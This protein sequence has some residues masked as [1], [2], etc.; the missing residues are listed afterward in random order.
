MRALLGSAISAVIFVQPSI[1]AVIEM[2]VLF[3]LILKMQLR[4]FSN[5]TLVLVSL[6]ICALLVALFNASYIILDVMKYG[7]SSMIK[8]IT[9]SVFPDVYVA[10]GITCAISSCL[11]SV[12]FFSQMPFMLVVVALFHVPFV[13][14]RV[15]DVGILQRVT[16]FL[17]VKLKQFVSAKPVP[18]LRFTVIRESACLN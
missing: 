7:F 4:P 14:S 2:P 10:P 13:R 3:T 11:A 1:V 6:V 9:L 12:E 16:L 17:P 8:L 5:V 18:L 15:A